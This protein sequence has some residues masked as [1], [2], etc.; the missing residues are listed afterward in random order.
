[1]TKCPYRANHECTQAFAF[2]PHLA[3]EVHVPFCKMCLH[4]MLCDEIGLN[5]SAIMSLSGDKM[6]DTYR[7]RAEFG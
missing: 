3:W 2:K 7:K 5:T 4:G 6:E 1:M